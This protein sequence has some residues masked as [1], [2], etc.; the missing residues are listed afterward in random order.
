V[1]AQN[2]PAEPGK[3]AAA[4]TAEI[5]EQAQVF[6][7]SWALVGS[8]FDNGTAL[9]DA[10]EALEELRVMVSSLTAL[11]ARAALA[12]SPQP[13]AQQPKPLDDP[14][15]QELFMSAITGAMAFG[16]QGTDRP[17]VGH[18][19][20]QAWQIGRAEAEK[21]A[22]QQPVVVP[23]GF[24]LVS[25][26]QLGD[27]RQQANSCG[28]WTLKADRTRSVVQLKKAIRE[29]MEAAPQAPSHDWFST[30]EI[31]EA[32]QYAEVSDGQFT[33]M[34]IALNE[35]Y[36]ARAHGITKEGGK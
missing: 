19:L 9:D 5:M 27:W 3:D 36:K 25:V 30:T 31:A 4:A 2:T 33:A 13:A 22:A 20:N 17:P 24:R 18:W 15:L 35:V 14:R 7:S 16:Y 28:A 26:E 10:K 34:L 11:A 32:A 23:E 21:V 6:A 29:A 12:A 8:R 1:S